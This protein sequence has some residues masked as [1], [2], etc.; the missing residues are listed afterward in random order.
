MGSRN[1]TTTTL[2]CAIAA[3]SFFITSCAGTDVF[4]RNV[5][6]N[7]IDGN[8]RAALQ[9][10]DRNSFMY[11]EKNSV[12]YNLDKG[13]TFHYAKEYDSSNIYLLNAEKIIED[14]YTK[15]ISKEA[16]SILLNDNVLP[17]EGEDFEKVLLNVFL[18]LNFAQ[19]GMA[20]DALVEARKVDLKLRE[21]A[22]KYEEKNRYKEDAFIRYVAGILY[23]NEGEVNDAFISYQK[24]YEAYDIYSKE[25]GT[26]APSFLLDD[27]VR[28]ATLL[29]FSDEAAKYASLGGAGY[30]KGAENFGSIAV[31]VY[32]GLGPFKTEERIGV[33]IPDSSGT[34][35]TFQVALPKF[36]QR[37]YGRN[38][39]TVSLV[40]QTDSSSGCTDIGE[41]ITSIAG[42]S[43]DDRL[44]LIYLKSGGRAL[45]KFLASEKMKSEMKKGKN[46]EAVNILGSLAVDLVVG[47]T[48]KADLRS[49]RLLPAEIQMARFFKSPGTYQI[50]VSDK[51]QNRVLKNETVNIQNGKTLFIIINDIGAPNIMR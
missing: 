4:Y 28:T 44:A 39:Y 46:S 19:K 37:C 43:L 48:E 12:L 6:K 36:Q 32:S 9:E 15:S 26:P 51:R 3:L 34:L 8:Y 40:N 21:Y 25:Y 2:R 16:L 14:L 50:E 17:Y 29:S 31:I 35:H 11:G 30:R 20:E 33:S 24:S 7:I 23:E 41:D 38:S 1:I 45:L 42:K 18:A 49:W 22:R 5:E 13:L 27:L 47:A 10:I